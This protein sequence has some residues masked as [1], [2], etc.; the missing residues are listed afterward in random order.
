MFLDPLTSRSEIMKSI[1]ENAEESHKELVA[2]INNFLK[3][4]IS[5]KSEKQKTLWENFLWRLHHAE[6]VRNFSDDAEVKDA[7]SCLTD[8]MIELFSNDKKFEKFMFKRLLDKPFKD[9][10]IMVKDREF[11]E[12]RLPSVETMLMK[13]YIMHLYKS[14]L[15]FKDIYEMPSTENFKKLCQNKCKLF[16]LENK[17]SLEATYI[18][19]LF[20]YKKSIKEINSEFGWLSLYQKYINGLKAYAGIE[21][22]SVQSLIVKKRKIRIYRF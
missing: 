16:T 14:E 12:F 22:N 18:D 8:E 17:K 7:L 10:E 2:M 5:E 19:K 3:G 11:S 9:L 21:F 20:G 1:R 15:G 4:V 6:L 13:A